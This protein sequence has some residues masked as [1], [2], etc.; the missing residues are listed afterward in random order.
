MEAK[1]GW[2][3]IPQWEESMIFLRN[4][5]QVRVSVVF[6]KTKLERKDTTVGLKCQARE[7]VFHS[8]ARN[9]KFY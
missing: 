6:R 3:L 8:T 2:L 4:R 1:I 7:S 9:R 5:E